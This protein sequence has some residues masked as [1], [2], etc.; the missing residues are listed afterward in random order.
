MALRRSRSGSYGWAPLQ[1]RGPPH[2]RELT[3]AEDD[4]SLLCQGCVLHPVE[5]GQEAS[6]F[7]RGAHFVAVESDWSGEGID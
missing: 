4:V 6:H 1:A 5:G 3:A 7:H 2:L